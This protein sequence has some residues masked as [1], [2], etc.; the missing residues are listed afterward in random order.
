MTRLSAVTVLLASTTVFATGERVSLMPANS[1]LK[2]TVCVSMNCEAGTADATVTTR[3]CRDGLEITVTMASGQ[4][5]LTQV[6]PTNADGTI[7]STDLVRATSQVLKAIEEG[8]V[9]AEAPTTAVAKAQK[10]KKP[11]GK[12]LAHR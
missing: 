11:R 3:A 6:V 5:R 2:E 10:P 1:P 4:R 7:S 9:K 12:L 8:P